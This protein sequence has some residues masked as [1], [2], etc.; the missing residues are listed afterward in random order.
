MK[1]TSQAKRFSAKIIGIGCVLAGLI[2][3]GCALWPFFTGPR[4]TEK[5]LGMAAAELLAQAIRLNTVNPPGD[6]RPVA[7]L[8]ERTLRRRGLETKLIPTPPGGSERG[9]AALWA[10]LPGTGRRRPIVLLSHLDVVPAEP[11]AWIVD[12]FEGVLS[13]GNVVGRGAL[14]AKGVAVVHLFA[15]LELLQRDIELDRDVIL[16]ATPDE[17]TGGRDGAGFIVRQRRDLLRNAEYL[18]TEGGGILIDAADT[19]PVW[20]VAVT[21]K[22]PC[23]LEITATGTSGHSAAEPVDAA[24][25]R[26]IA[27]LDRVRRFE[28]EL[29]VVPEVEKMFAALAPLAPPEQRDAYRDLP[30]SLHFDPPFRSSFLADRSRAAL[31]RDTIAI[32][33]LEGSQRTNVIPASARAHLDVRLLPGESCEEFTNTLR[34]T[35]ADPGVQIEPLLSFKTKSSPA[36]TELFRAIE[37]VAMKIDPGA[38][39]VPRVIAGFTDAHY[40]RDLGIVAYGFVPRWLPADETRGIHGSNERI[41]LDNLERGIETLIRILVELNAE[42]SS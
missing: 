17:E 16:L 25:P 31:V 14:D 41:S 39:V 19:P 20:G 40:F 36:D 35:I 37:R 29:R 15:L 23:W 21:E 38:L 30:F 3:Q 9:R 10:R 42:P 6:E 8:F 22:I 18:L 33:V 26:L 24:V 4:G 5:S 32:T 2:L 7:E 12:P 1:Q 27:A 13:G 28:T 34:L 11:K